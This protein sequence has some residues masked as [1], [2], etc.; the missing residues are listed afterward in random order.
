MYRTP[1]GY[2][3]FAIIVLIGLVNACSQLT[4]I[5]PASQDQP[6][7]VT[8]N[9]FIVQ[10]P[11]GYS[12][13]IEPGK[14]NVTMSTSVGVTAGAH[15]Q[16]SGS[17]KNSGGVQQFSIAI[18]QHNQTLY[19]VTANSAADAGGHVPDLLSIVGSN[20]VGGAGSTPLAV[21]LSTPVVVTTSATNFNGMATTLTVIYNP[22]PIAIGGGSGGGGSPGG[23]GDTTGRLFLTADH[24]LGPFSSQTGPPD[25]CQAHMVWSLTPNALTGTTGTSNPTTFQGDYDPPPSWIANPPSSLWSADCGYG[26]MIANLR[27]GSWTVAVTGNQGTS[28]DPGTAWQTQCQVVLKPGMNVARFVWGRNGC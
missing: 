9:G 10:Q 8:L 5:P 17:A 25:L 14:E 16:F 20:G 3:A 18:R 2:L 13:D 19:Q 12:G 15:V 26:Q 24:Q 4:S 7:T 22:V 28:S 6:P 21:V 23:S 11:S 27:T 1:P